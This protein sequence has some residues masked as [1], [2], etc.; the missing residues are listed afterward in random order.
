MCS[1]ASIF[2]IYFS[3]I[4]ILMHNKAGYKTK[5]Y[6]NGLDWTRCCRS[7]YLLPLTKNV[8]VT[9]KQ[10]PRGVI[11]KGCSENMQ[12]THAEMRFGEHH[13]EHHAEVAEQIYWNHT[14]V[15]VLSYEFAAY[16]Q[17]TFY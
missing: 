2:F 12:Q 17:N 4:V 16:F 8:T 9:Q 14:L 10:P 13:A 15:W 7:A 11:R 6:S 3:S 1:F 5:A